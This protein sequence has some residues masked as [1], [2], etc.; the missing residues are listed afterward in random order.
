M[1]EIRLAGKKIVLSKCKLLKSSKPDEN[2]LEDWMPMGGEWSYKDG[3]LYGKEN[4]NKGGLLFSKVP[5]TQ[6]V[7]MEF[8][9]STVLP[10]TRDV[11]AVFC[12]SWNEETDY[13]KQAYVCGL[14]GWWENKA[15]IESFAKGGFCCLT[16][17]YKYEPGKEV[18]MIVGQIHGHC[19]MVVDGQLVMEYIDPTP[20][21]GG[22]VGFSP[23]CTLLKIHNIEIKEIY[24]ETFKQK[25]T[26]EF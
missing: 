5:Y 18:H 11:N 21:L 12:A 16:N 9:I 3:F 2:W 6:D 4:G 15:G 7:L 22:H 24:W 26:P 10:A 20:I 19:F 1:E 8:D 25:Y 14:N 13:L 23:Y 17:S